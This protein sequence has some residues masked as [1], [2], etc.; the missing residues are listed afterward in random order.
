MQPLIKFL[1]N[2][3]LIL[4][5]RVVVGGVFIAAGAVKLFEPIEDFIAIGRQWEIIPDPLLTW[6][7]TALPWVEFIFGILLLLGVLRR[8][9]ASIIGLTLVSF[10]IG[11]VTNM[12]RG[13]TLA[14]CGC[15]GNAF[16]FGSSFGELL[17]RDSVLLILCVI[18]IASTQSWLSVD[19]YL[20]KKK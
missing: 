7:M 17:F 19:G 13:R 4:G 18:L 20:N 9:S 5:N 3:Y 8:V 15:F 11:I 12:I 10:I 1:N 14:D 16:E 2:Q 6:Y